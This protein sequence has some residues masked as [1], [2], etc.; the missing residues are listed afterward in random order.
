MEDPKSTGSISQ[1]RIDKLNEA[2]FVWNSKYVSSLIF[3][4]LL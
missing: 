1:E 4:R 2:G 3:V